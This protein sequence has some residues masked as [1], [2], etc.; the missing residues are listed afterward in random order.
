MEKLLFLFVVIMGMAGYIVLSAYRDDERFFS[1]PYQKGWIES[2]GRK[3]ARTLNF[4]FGSCVGL[5]AI[6][7]IIKIVIDF[8][9]L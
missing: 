5:F 4:I 9:L 7:M 1:T 3:G 8:E 2:L 6:Y